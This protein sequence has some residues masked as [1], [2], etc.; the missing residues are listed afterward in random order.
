MKSAIAL[1]WVV[2]IAN[3]V[4]LTM[5]VM[6]VDQIMNND[7]L[8]CNKYLVDWIDVDL[9]SHAD[10]RNDIHSLKD[11][12]LLLR[13]ELNFEVERNREAY[14]QLFENQKYIRGRVEHLETQHSVVTLAQAQEFDKINGRIKRLEG[15]VNQR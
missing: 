6:K 7:C 4:A 3:A 12:D 1:L 13:G 10:I 14:D 9:D 5:T 2:V 15:I 11:E 8:H